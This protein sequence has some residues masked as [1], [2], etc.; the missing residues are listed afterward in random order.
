MEH[1]QQ[2]LLFCSQKKVDEGTRYLP[3]RAG[4]PMRSDIDIMGFQNL[5]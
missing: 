1:N 5:P 4:F 3:Q 2:W